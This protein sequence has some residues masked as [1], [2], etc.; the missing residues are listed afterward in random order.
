MTDVLG[1]ALAR[2]ETLWGVLCRDASI[3]DLEL[4]QR[5]GYRIVWFDLEHGGM[6][7]AD[8]M[9]LSRTADHLGMVSA[10]RIP[11]LSRA[12]VQPLLDQAVRIVIL[13]DVADAS[14]A[15]G[16]VELG[17][18]PPLGQRGASSVAPWN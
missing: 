14:H 6:N 7:L 11:V 2:K 4:M 13:P 9:R 18:F 8:V 17:R 15:A 10:V 5:A 3:T 1:D 12:F 16:L